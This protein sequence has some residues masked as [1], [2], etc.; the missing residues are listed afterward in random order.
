MEETKEEVVRYVKRFWSKVEMKGDF[1]ECWNWT[2][3]TFWDGYGQF[4]PI[5]YASPVRAHRE[6]YLL[7][8][9][10]D[11]GEL[12]VCHACDNRK[13]CNP[14]HLFLGTVK[15][16]YDDAERKGRI[17]RDQGRILSHDY[18]R[19]FSRK[20]FQKSVKRKN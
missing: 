12:F 17:I 1:D 9:N 3:S 8:Y 7:W 5:S 18:L 11:P 19:L 13:C 14:H 16:N 4:K 15:D 6:A 10:E 2:A 20:I